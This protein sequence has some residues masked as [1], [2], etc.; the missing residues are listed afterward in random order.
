MQELGLQYLKDDFVPID[1]S[2]QKTVNSFV[3]CWNT[4]TAPW[5]WDYDHGAWGGYCPHCA[6]QRS[7]AMS[8]VAPYSLWCDAKAALPDHT[9]NEYGIACTLGCIPEVCLPLEYNK[10]A[11]TVHMK[12]YDGYGF[13]MLQSIA[14]G[15]LVIVPRGFHRYR[16]AGRVLIPNL[17]C[18]ESEWNSSSLTGV[19]KDFTSDLTMANDMSLAC[20]KASRGLFNFDVEAKRI[21][22]FL[23]NLR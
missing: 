22:K 14:M 16:T 12:T 1:S 11:L 3:N 13:S 6:G 5:V 2:T 18:L 10:G 7:P 23:E 4:F 8:P 19:I 15:R 21:S 9:F 20:Y 17:T